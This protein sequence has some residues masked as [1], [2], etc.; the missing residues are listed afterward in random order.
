M[1]D[2]GFPPEPA[3]DAE[4]LFCEA[5]QTTRDCLGTSRKR[6]VG[7]DSGSKNDASQAAELSF[8]SPLKTRYLFVDRQGK[9]VL[10]C[11]PA[12]CKTFPRTARS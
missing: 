4:R 12:S 3:T 10:E 8:I 9:T 5:G 7:K 11:W 1:N 2:V 6:V